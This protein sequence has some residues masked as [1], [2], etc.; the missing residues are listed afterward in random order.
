MGFRLCERTDESQA[1]EFMV[2][3]AIK[4]LRLLSEED[5]NNTLITFPR[6]LPRET[7]GCDFLRRVWGG[8]EAETLP[9]G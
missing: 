5:M 2:E 9:G 6:F 4:V 7:S 3:N 1:T 8:S